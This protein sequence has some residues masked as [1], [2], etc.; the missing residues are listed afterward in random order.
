MALGA[1]GA[2]AALTAAAAI[3]QPA[4]QHE[5]VILDDFRGEYSH[6]AL[7]EQVLKGTSE[8]G[9]GSA[10]EVRRLSV[11]LGAHL[12]KLDQPGSLDAYVRTRFLTPIGATT[13]AL[14]EVHGRAV[15]HQSQGASESRIVE[16]L[17]GRAS[18]DAPFRADLAAQLDLPA[19]TGDKELLQALLDRVHAVH[20]SPEIAEARAD[21]LQAAQAA[22]ARG[23]IRVLSAGNQGELSRT[24]EKLQVRVPEGFYRSDLADPSAVIVG[25]SDDHGTANPSDD[26]VAAL[27]SPEAGALV[28]M[29]GVDRP[30]CMNGQVHH[31]SGSS[32]AAPQ[33]SRLLDEAWLRAPET[34]RDELVARL[35]RS[36]PGGEAWV[37]KG[38]VDAEGFLLAK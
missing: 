25:A 29:D 27:A 1:L 37:G 3:H 5:L 9:V 32:Y 35:Q 8:C 10:R 17:W 21:L 36:V 22:T 7:V 18:G 33:A 2:M 28:G 30:A 16:S 19:S 15:M 13:R 31:H 14:G 34:S 23:A 6:G 38:I 11:D 12:D 26:G 20:G 4:P 24:F